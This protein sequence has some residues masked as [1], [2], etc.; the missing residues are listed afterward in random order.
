MSDVFCCCHCHCYAI[1]IVDLLLALLY[2]LHY[3][4]RV[5]IGNSFKTWKE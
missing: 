4:R 2:E 3:Q 5:W 1:I